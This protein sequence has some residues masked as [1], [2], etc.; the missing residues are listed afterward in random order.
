MNFRSVRQRLLLLAVPMIA[1]W[2]LVSTVV[3]VPVCIGLNS[4]W[5]QPYFSEIGLSLTVDADENRIASTSLFTSERTIRNN[6]YEPKLELNGSTDIELPSFS[7]STIGLAVFVLLGLASQMSYRKLVVGSLVMF[8]I[9]ALAVG[10]HIYKTVTDVLIEHQS[11]IYAINAGFVT[12]PNIPDAQ[13]YAYFA[14][15]WEVLSYGGAV[16][17]PVVVWWFLNSPF[18]N[19]IDLTDHSV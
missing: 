2:Y 1:C 16:V 9:A 19:Q 6:A 7:S 5:L 11:S 18:A 13:L 14:N 3:I 4:L 12:R 8:A 15:F 10:V 17:V